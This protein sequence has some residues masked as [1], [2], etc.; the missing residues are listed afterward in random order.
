[1]DSS[2]SLAILDFVDTCR[3]WGDQAWL[4]DQ[5]LEVALAEW[6]AVWVPKINV[7][8]EGKERDD[9]IAWGHREVKMGWE[10]AHPDSW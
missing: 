2:G 3:E 4:K 6:D 1:M 10:N 9:I 5:P 8:A 7:V